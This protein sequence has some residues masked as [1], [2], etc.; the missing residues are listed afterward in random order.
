MYSLQHT[1]F[2]IYNYSI[3]E[4]CFSVNFGGHRFSYTLFKRVC[5]YALRLILT[6][7]FTLITNLGS[8]NSLINILY[9]ILYSCLFLS[10]RNSPSGPRPPHYRGFTITLRHTTLGRT[11]LGEWSTRST[12]LYLTK[13]HT[14]KRQTS[15]TPAGFEPTIP[16][17]ERSQTNALDRAVTGTCIYVFSRQ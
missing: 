5:H 11:P 12:D 10:W 6:Q 9:Y 7:I 8:H 16:A 2:F 15:M 1:C 3:D 13:H 17:S 4:L 14:H